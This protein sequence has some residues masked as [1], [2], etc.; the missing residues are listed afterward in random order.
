[1]GEIIPFPAPENDSNREVFRDIETLA[2]Q[3]IER[4]TEILK[5]LTTQAHRDTTSVDQRNINIR[6]EWLDNA[7]NEELF[8]RLLEATD[9][10]ISQDAT[11]YNAMIRIL[12]S[13]DAL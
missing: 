10:Q 7:S 1:M 11:W 2:P 6:Q 4:I 5:L 12:R 8:Q 13:R 3:D 9:E